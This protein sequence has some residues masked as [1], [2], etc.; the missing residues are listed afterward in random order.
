[1]AVAGGD[2]EE[3]ELGLGDQA[4]AVKPFVGAVKAMTPKDFKAPN[5][6]QAPKSCM[7]LKWAHGFRSFDTKNNLKYNNQGQV[8]FC[9]AGVGVVQDLTQNTQNF[10]NM[11]R[12]DIVSLA[13]HKG[14]NIVA[15]GQMA[16]KE[17]N[18]KSA[19]VN[20]KFVEGKLV[21]IFLWDAS[22]C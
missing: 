9:T 16:G 11:H 14:N 15:T 8:V 17:V 2:F 3:E 10:F 12:E 22:T 4:L 19:R 21:N 7:E 1:M 18:E 20:K 13:Y 6:R 5:P